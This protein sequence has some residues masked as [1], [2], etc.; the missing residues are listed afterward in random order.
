MSQYIDIPKEDILKT[1]NKDMTDK[2]SG[3][4]LTAE[5]EKLEWTINGIRIWFIKDVSTE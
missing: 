4:G 5:I 2:M 1:I 3:I